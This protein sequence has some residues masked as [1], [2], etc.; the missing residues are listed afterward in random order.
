[1]SRPS[2]G[3]AYWV[4]VKEYFRDSE[5]R[6]ARKVYFDKKRDRFDGTCRDALVR[7][8]VPRDSGIYI[9]PPPKSEQLYSN[10]LSVS[11]FADRLYIADTNYRSYKALW[12]KLHSLGGEIG[13]EWK[14]KEKRIT[15]FRNLEEYPWREICDLGTLEDFDTEEWAYSDDPDRRRD[16]VQLLNLALREKV[17]PDLR[18]S[19]RKDCYYFRATDDLSPRKISYT[20]PSGRTTPRTVFKGYLNKRDPTRIAYYRHSAFEGQFKLFDGAWYL[21]ITPTY[22]FT[23]NGY[24]LDRWYENRLKGI[25]RLE[26]HPAVFGQVFMW[27]DHLSRPS[28]LFTPEYPFLK[29]DALQRFNIKVG[30]DDKAWLSHESDEEAESTRSSLSELPL[31]E[32]C[33]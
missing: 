18:Y 26:K 15:S 7:L 13:C 30:I 19:E 2:A 23:W 31:F 8:A 3:E 6:E 14:L 21:E 12:A 20:S 17:W 9:A 1:V 10:L 16:F 33:D 28:D 5:R 32:L 25:K 24:R 29:F 22:Y 27:A 4:S 11:S